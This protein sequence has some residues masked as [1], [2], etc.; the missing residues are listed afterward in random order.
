MKQKLIETMHQVGY[1]TMPTVT[2][3]KKASGVKDVNADARDEA[4]EAYQ[5]EVA[6]ELQQQTTDSE[7]TDATAED[8]TQTDTAENTPET[9]DDH[10]SV[11]EEQ[12]PSQLSQLS[13]EAVIEQMQKDDDAAA[14]QAKADSTKE[15]VV[16]E[17]VE[18]PQDE[19]I[20]VKVTVKT[21]G[22]CRLKR[23]WTGTEETLL[24]R[25]QI[26]VLETDP[27]F[28]VVEL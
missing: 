7:S 21:D 11:D 3:L 4:W 20:P 6:Q 9:D 22:F 10:E 17:L 18:V 14:E 25:E 13:E 12:Q 19:R 8:A 15:P 23:R 5:E 27:E 26:T 1:L 16:T 2:E 24:T 28:T